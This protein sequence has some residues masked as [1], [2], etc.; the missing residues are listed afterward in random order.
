MMFKDSVVYLFWF[1]VLGLFLAIYA[2]GCGTVTP[3]LESGGTGGEAGAAAHDA[4][5][6]DALA[7][8]GPRA[9]DAAAGVDAAACISPDTAGLA[10]NDTCD[11]GAPTSKGCHAG[12]TIGA[13]PFVGCTTGAYATRCYASC[14]YCP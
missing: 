3:L 11:G 2:A 14:G 9:R 8:L 13:A 1:L 7:E 12:C 10:I 4:A 5:A 6:A